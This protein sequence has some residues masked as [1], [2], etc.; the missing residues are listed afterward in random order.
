M[1][2]DVILVEALPNYRLKLVFKNKEE[3]VFDV[4]PY[5]EKGIFAELKDVF[6]FRQVKV[7]FGT[8]EW[9]NHQDFSKDTLYGLS[10]PIKKQ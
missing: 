9:P 8:V 2:P 1:N 10:A 4:T 5:L 6:Y 3:R 7:S